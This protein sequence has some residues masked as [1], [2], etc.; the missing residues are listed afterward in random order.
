MEQHDDNETALN[1]FNKLVTEALC[2]CK[3]STDSTRVQ[4]NHYIERSSSRKLWKYVIVG[5]CS[6]TRE[7]QA[8]RTEEN[9]L[10]FT[11]CFQEAL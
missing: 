11:S 9:I 3:R 10:G 8:V 4:V 5:T 7:K 2:S 1:K 6:N